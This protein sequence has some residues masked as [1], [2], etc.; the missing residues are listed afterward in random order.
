MSGNDFGPILAWDSC[1]FLAWFNDEKDKPLNVIDVLLR[2]VLAKKITLLV[3]AV[4]GMEVLDQA[5]K[6]DAGTKFKGFV[7]RPS[8][9]RADLDWRISE[10]AAA[11]REMVSAEVAAKRMDRG[12]KAPDAAIAAT[13]IVYRAVELHTFDPV[14]LS[15]N[16]SPIVGG[17]HISVP[18]MLDGSKTLTGL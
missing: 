4:C 6:S 5:G 18:R 13:A 11:I 14:L 1:V 17:L 15:L 12:I 10:R 7:K 3:S 8:I 9:I 2:Q 16:K